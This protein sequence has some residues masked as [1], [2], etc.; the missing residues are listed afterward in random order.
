[1]P[2]EQLWLEMSLKFTEDNVKLA[3]WAVWREKSSQCGQR[4]A[5]PSL[6]S[7][8]S[9][10]FPSNFSRSSTIVVHNTSISFFFHFCI[11]I[12][13]E[14]NENVGYIMYRGYGTCRQRLEYKDLISSLK[15]KDD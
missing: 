2:L 9:S 4:Y 6:S 12:S 1:M 3:L 14:V 7:N 8:S 5:L 10:K 11:S 15:Q 13:I